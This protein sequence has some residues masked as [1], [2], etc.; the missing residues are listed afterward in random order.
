MEAPRRI[1]GSRRENAGEKKGRRGQVGWRS[2]LVEIKRSELA[3]IIYRSLGCLCGLYKSE[4]TETRY[5][6]INKLPVVQ[7]LDLCSSSAPPPRRPT[8]PSIVRFHPLA[9]TTP[10]IF[11]TRVT[12]NLPSTYHSPDPVSAADASRLFLF[13]FV[14]PRLQETLIS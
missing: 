2:Q 12:R 1:L 4:N 5:N 6:E 3:N 9:R 11:S 7:R 8:P 14:S 13:I 10:S